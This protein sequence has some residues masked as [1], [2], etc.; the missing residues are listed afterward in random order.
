MVSAEGLVAIVLKENVPVAVYGD[1][2]S[3]SGRLDSLVAG[4]VVYVP[5][6]FEYAET[7]ISLSQL[8]VSVQLINPVRS[9]FRAISDPLVGGQ[10]LLRVDRR[11]SRFLRQELR[12]ETLLPYLLSVSNRESAKAL[13]SLS[14]LLR[15]LRYGLSPFSTVDYHHVG[16]MLALASNPFWF[17]PVSKPDRLSKW[18]AFFHVTPTRIYRFLQGASDPRLDLV[19]AAMFG[20]SPDEGSV[21]SSIIQ[22]RKSH[23][24]LRSALSKFLAAVF[25]LWVDQLERN[26]VSG[27][28][29]TWFDPDFV[30]QDVLTRS[31]FYR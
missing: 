19:T 5:G 20:A 30:F 18:R 13:W 8:P 6:L 28:S 22:R 25:Y 4:R 9:G 14:P 16:H 2:P 23:G 17:V 15:G 3:Q 27:A 10:V 7:I 26:T 29:R 1:R 24:S 31:R 12:D 21:L 11:S